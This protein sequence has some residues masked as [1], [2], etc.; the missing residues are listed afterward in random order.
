MKLFHE[1]TSVTDILSLIKIL[2][3]VV[4]LLTHIKHFTQQCNYRETK[5]GT[6]KMPVILENKVTLF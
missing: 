2:F 4:W 3:G 6:M 5:W 1:N